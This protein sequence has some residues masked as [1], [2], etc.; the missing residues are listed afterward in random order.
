MGELVIIKK[1]CMTSPD[2]GAA[3]G[4]LARIAGNVGVIPRKLRIFQAGFHVP[5][6]TY[7]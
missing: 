4:Y 2:R 1:R 7:Q 5:Y 6:I 3:L